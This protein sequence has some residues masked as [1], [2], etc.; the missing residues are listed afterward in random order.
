MASRLG[1]QITAPESMSHSQAPMRAA[2]ERMLEPL[3][4]FAQCHLG[5][6]GPVRA[7]ALHAEAKL[8]GDG[9]GKIDL[10]AAKSCGR[11]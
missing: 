7:D 6:A 2:L 3:L 8:A 11:S 10:G 5:L 1:D 4:A 9:Q